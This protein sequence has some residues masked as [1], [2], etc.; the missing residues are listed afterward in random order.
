MDDGRIQYS[1]AKIPVT[2]LLLVETLGIR[3]A[4]MTSKG[5]AFHVIIKSG[6]QIAISAIM[7]AI[8]PPSIIPNIV[9]DILVLASAIRNINIAYC[10]RHMQYSNRYNSEKAHP[11]YAKTI[12]I[13][14]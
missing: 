6:I 8:K 1:Y 9:V 10:S 3:E 5:K 7:G 14:Q 11:C 4:V 2:V 12:F 13:Y